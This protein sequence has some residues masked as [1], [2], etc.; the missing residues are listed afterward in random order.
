MQDGHKP[1][2]DIPDP[3]RQR[4]DKHSHTEH[5]HQHDPL[6]AAAASVCTQNGQHAQQEIQSGIFGQR[7]QPDTDTAT[8]D[9]A[10]NISA[11]LKGMGKTKQPG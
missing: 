4:G 1:V 10:I 2:A 5:Q 7:R 3:G 6:A 11:G 8:D 9:P